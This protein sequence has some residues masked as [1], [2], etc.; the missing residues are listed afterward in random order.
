MRAQKNASNTLFDQYNLLGKVIIV[1]DIKGLCET[2][3]FIKNLKLGFSFLEEKII[4]VEKK[5]IEAKV[6]VA[7]RFTGNSKV[8]LTEIEIDNQHFG[9]EEDYG[10]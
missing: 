10:A 1:E 2:P 8:I 3:K 4:Q 5:A 7:Q 9:E 6:A